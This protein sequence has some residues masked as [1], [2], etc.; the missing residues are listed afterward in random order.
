[1]S[2]DILN[3]WTPTNTNTNIP[4]L[5]A[6]NYS[7]GGDLSD[8]WLR[9]ASYLRLR[10][11]SFGYTFDKKLL[12]GTGINGLKLFVQG[13]RTHTNRKGA[14]VLASLISIEMKKNPKLKSLVK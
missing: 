11:I 12:K 1:M 14:D 2:V 7:Q 8:Q 6:V 9:D 4:S 10:N 3:A 13:D 5:D